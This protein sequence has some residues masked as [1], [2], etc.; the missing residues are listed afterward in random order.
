MN[1]SIEIDNALVRKYHQLDSHYTTYPTADRFIE[2]YDGKAHRLTLRQRN[3]MAGGA[4][5]NQPLSLYVHLPFCETGCYFCD[6]HRVVSKDHGRAVSYLHFLQREISLTAALLE[7]SRRVAEV[8]LGGGTPTFLTT[9]QLQALMAGLSENFDLQPGEYTIE[10]DPR[11]ADEEKIAA[12]AALGFNHMNFGVQ[13]LAPA[14]QQAVNRVQT[15]AV[16]ARAITLARNY[17][18]ASINIDLMYGLPK[19]TVGGFE[20]TLDR[21]LRWR[22]DRV[23]LYGYTHT[24]STY[25]LQRSI[26]VSELPSV[27]EKLAIVSHGIAKLSAAGYTYIGKDHFALGHDALVAATTPAGMQPSF[28]DYAN[29]PGGDLI[30]FGISAI[31][32]VGA[33]YSQNV[34]TLD[35]Y[36]DHLQQNALPVLRGIELNGDDL[37]RRAVI[38]SLM[39]RFELSIDAIEIAHLIRFN[40][41]FADEWERLEILERDGLVTLATEW[42]TVTAKGR[43]LVRAIARVFDRYLSQRESR[44]HSP[45]VI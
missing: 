16:T 7:G 1:P 15:E 43:L 24:P 32:R 33:S 45:S 38:Q 25:K 28:Q 2:A 17:G 34:T 42:I 35:A 30:G 41:Y 37:V 11:T 31:S 40:E 23:A 21:V 20:A 26:E 27:A 14:V 9:A 12:L 19:Q 10:I 5:N 4:T 13:D 29:R 6:C 3:F 18:V 39:R 22:P 44:Q 36:Y 8:H